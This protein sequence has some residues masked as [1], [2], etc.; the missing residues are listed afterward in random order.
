MPLRPP[1]FRAPG[2]VPAPNK[3][4]EA[5]DPYYGSAE[6]KRLRIACLKRDGFRCAELDCETPNRGKGGRLIAHHI[7]D[8]RKGG[9]DT[10]ANLRT[11][12]PACDN[13]GHAEKGVV[14]KG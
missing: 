13:R 8:R 3:R 1:T 2:L 6:W 10:L 11:R 14:G 9:P 12:C 7:I 4:P 5:H